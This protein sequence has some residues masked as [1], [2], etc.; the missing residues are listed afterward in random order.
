MGEGEEEGEG[1]GV[2]GRDEERVR[3]ADDKQTPQHGLGDQLRVRLPLRLDCILCYSVGVREETTRRRSKR[4][5]G[6]RERGKSETE[7]VSRTVFLA[8]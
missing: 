2:E 5:E 4:N 7:L 6:R 1:G 3:A 8:D